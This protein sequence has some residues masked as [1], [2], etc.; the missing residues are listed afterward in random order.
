MAD[1][2]QSNSHPPGRSVKRMVKKS[3]RVDL[4]PMV[5]LGFLLVTFFVFTTT[6]SQPKVMNII[7]PDDKKIGINDKVCASCA[8]TFV[9]GNNNALF[10]YGGQ[11]EH[12]VYQQ[13]TYNAGGMR[14]VIMDKKKHMSGTNMDKLT[15]IIKSSDVST[16][17]NMVDLLDEVQINN[18][19]K[20]LPGGF[21][22]CR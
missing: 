3:T 7:V 12:A 22:C 5:D 6:M 4:T 10:Y 17:R 13:T 19:K 9:L 18:I 14:K 21:E 11:D 2:T 16:I 15:M 20:I 1:I 8:L